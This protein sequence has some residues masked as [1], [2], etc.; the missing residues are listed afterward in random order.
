MIW[1]SDACQRVKDLFDLNTCDLS[2]V[3]FEGIFLN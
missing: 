3:H 2:K 1:S